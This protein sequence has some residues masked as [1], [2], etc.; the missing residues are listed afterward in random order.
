MKFSDFDK[1]A[2]ALK[3]GGEELKAKIVN[4]QQEQET[5]SRQLD[6]LL[7]E[8]N[9]LAKQLDLKEF[10]FEENVTINDLNEYLERIFPNNGLKTDTDR[11]FDMQIADYIVAA[12]AGGVAV[13]VDALLVKIPKI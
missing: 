9:V 4:L 10:K 13:I 11:Q 6:K 1:E 5:V 8:I 7:H 3:R 12:L 2:D